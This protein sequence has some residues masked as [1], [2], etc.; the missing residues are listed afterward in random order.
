ML[1]MN[2]FGT[3]QIVYLLERREMLG[4]ASKLAGDKKRDCLQGQRHLS[5]LYN[6]SIC[7]MPVPPRLIY[8]LHED[9]NRASCQHVLSA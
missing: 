4:P 7:L 3:E 9:R 5:Y 2:A 6:Y 1:L 8:E